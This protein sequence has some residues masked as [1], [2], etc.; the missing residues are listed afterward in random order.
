MANY[1]FA[2]GKG[3][4]I[5]ADYD[6]NM[7]LSAEQVKNE[8]KNALSNLFDNVIVSSISDEYKEN[9]KICI[10]IE[11]REFVTYACIKGTTPGGR[12]NLMNEQRIQMKA[13]Y[14]NYA[15]SKKLDGHNAVCLGVYKH[16]SETIFCAW[17]LN[18]STAADETPISK[19]I[20]IHT[21]ARALTEGFVQQ[22]TGSG[23]YVC[24]FR[25]DFIY[26]YLKNCSWL[27]EDKFTN[28]NNYNSDD[29]EEFDSQNEDTQNDNGNSDI[30]ANILFYG[31]P[32]AGKSYE[33]DKM[34]E[35]SRSERVVFHPDYTYSDFVGQILPRII[36]DKLKYVFEPGPFTKMLQRAYEDPE[37]NM[38][39]LVIEEINRGN[40]PAIFG[41]IFQLLDRNPDGSG[42][43]HISNYDIASVVYGDENHE[44]RIPSNLT[45]LATMNTSDQN[46]FTLD[47]AFQRRWEMHMI[48]NRV[49]KAI[50]AGNYIEGCN[51]TWGRFAEVTNEE[52]IKYGEETG[53]SED[54]RLGAYFAQPTELSKD[55]F[56]EKV[57]KYLWD[58]AFRMD[59]YVYFNEN[60]SSL[61]NI[62]DIFNESESNKD[63]LLKRVLKYN[64]YLKMLNQTAENDNEY[65]NSE[66]EENEDE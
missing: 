42:K 19:Q 43:Y 33:I 24:A 44:V 48:M 53:G 59:H 13:K 7:A 49:D 16:D 1:E 55:K 9:F 4:I 60:I 35:D 37:K 36:D 66:Q 18:K 34:I 12:D 32:G 52:L 17:A 3:N 20:K 21:I 58:D 51:V 26:F 25:P 23:E 30:A 40:A 39:Y 62:I 31:V 41:D 54:K 11:D 6:R 10:P 65:A 61:D 28:L 38:Y 22:M 27:H 64:I 8:L 5:V 47:T 2:V 56:P 14:I 29:V 50:H 46:V 15:Y 57:L 45:L 63:D